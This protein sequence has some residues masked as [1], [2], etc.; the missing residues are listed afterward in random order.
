MT[1]RLSHSG[2][3]VSGNT[4]AENLLS[5]VDSVLRGVGQVMLQNNSYAGL[6]FLAGIFYNSR[7]FGLAVVVGTAVSTL[8]ATLLGVQASKVREG[9]FGFNGAL[10]GVALA[11]F[12]RA[13]P[14]TWAYL[15]FA[16][17]VA[18][19][20]M[21]TLLRLLEVWKLPALT[22]P[23]VITSLCFLLACGYFGRLQ[24]THILP[25]AGLPKEA[26]VEGVVTTTTVV[27]GLFKGVA[28]VFFQG[29]AVTGVLFL[30]GLLLSS[31]RIFTAALVGSI[32][33]VLVA[34]GLGAAEPAIRSG[35][36]GF[37]CVLTAIA[38]V[39]LGFALDKAA[40]GIYVLLATVATSVVFAATS[41]AL[42]PVGMPAL[43]LP[44]VLAVWI[45][46]LAGRQFP[47]LTSELLRP[48]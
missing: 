11:Y 16:A 20:L 23:F 14:L 25:T 32:T 5:F 15:V 2:L 28:Q 38:M 8:S 30:I 3:V 4:P 44:F 10:V 42:K 48:A 33:G 29:N 1:M 41:T 39:S 43:T 7:L 45:F 12:L 47:R 37:N 9:I 35:A 13:D 6:F 40:S 19:I 18:T 26:I 46:V 27:E 21:A 22:A 17:I 31:R 24:S 34:W 36:Y